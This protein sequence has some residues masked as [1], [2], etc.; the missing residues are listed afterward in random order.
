MIETIIISDLH[1]G[2]KSCYVDSIISFLKNIPTTNRLILNG[3]VIE[4]IECRLLPG[5]WEVLHILQSLNKKGIEV[6]WVKGNHDISA[7][8]I[9]KLIN[10]TFQKEYIFE[11]NNKKYLCMH[12]HQWDIFTEYPICTWMADKFYY[13][14]KQINLELSRKLKS[15]TKVWALCC[16]NVKWGICKLK[17]QKN[18][19][20]AFCGHTH[21]A[22]IDHDLRY[23]NSGSWTEECNWISIDTNENILLNTFK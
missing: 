17:S 13:Y 1:L 3:D 21:I 16:E 18:I 19:D 15:K 5:H 11:I 8:S 7:E 9:A 2:S 14:S 6:V 10:I 22:E 12:G 23:A 20:W 4:S